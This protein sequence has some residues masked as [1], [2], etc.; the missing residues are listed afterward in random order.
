M[1]FK[2]EIGNNNELFIDF[3]KKIRLKA[4]IL[5]KKNWTEIWQ[6]MTMTKLAE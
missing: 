5:F 3:E 2:F 4:N 1:N 6:I